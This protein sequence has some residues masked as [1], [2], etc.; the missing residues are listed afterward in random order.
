MGGRVL[1]AM[2]PLLF[3]G[4]VNAADN[5]VTVEPG[6]A[7]FMY[8][9][10]T[11]HLPNGTGTKLLARRVGA[12]KSLLVRRTDLV[13]D[14][15]RAVVRNGVGGMPWFTRVEVTD[16]ELEEIVNYLTRNNPR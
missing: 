6:Q 12:D 7:Y 8:H 10:E 16:A 15:V 11:C 2:L 9:C 1:L 4:V 3:W 14:Y 13:G 5:R